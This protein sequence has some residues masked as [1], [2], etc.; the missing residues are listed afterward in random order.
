MSGATD[1]FQTV[2]SILQ[3]VAASEIYL[4]PNEVCMEAFLRD[5]QF[6]ILNNITCTNILLK[7]LGKVD[8]DVCS[9]CC[10]P[11]EELKHLFYLCPFSQ[12]FWI[13]FKLLW[14][15]NIKED[16]TLSLK[17]III[18]FRGKDLDV[19]NYCILVGETR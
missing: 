1:L 4:L 17:E 15:E 13:D 6:K 7:K 9:F 3:K 10:R 2:V 11:R 8:S 19:L 18:G 14:F 5:F 12:V 16:I